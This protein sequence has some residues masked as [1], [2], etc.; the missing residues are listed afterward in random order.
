MPQSPLG[1]RYA[2]TALREKRATLAGEIAQLKKQIAWKTT[3]IKSVD[4]TLGLFDPNYSPGSIRAKK[5]YQRVHL[6][7]LRF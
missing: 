2:L 6:F 5:P 1:N 7:K 4:E 3:Q